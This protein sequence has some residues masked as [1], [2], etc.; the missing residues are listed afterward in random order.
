MRRIA[1]IFLG[2][3]IAA[4]A[5]D[6]AAAQSEVL[7][8]S[9]SNTIGERLAPALARKFAAAPPRGL[10]IERLEPGA[11][12]EQ[13]SLLFSGAE[14][15]RRLQVDIDSRG[16][17][18]GFPALAEHR[19]DIAMASREVTPHEENDIVREPLRSNAT[20]W[21]IGMD[22]VLV[23]VQPANPIGRLRRDQIENIFC[24]RIGGL[25]NPHHITD[26]S[27]VGGH[28]GRIQVYRRNDASGTTATFKALAMQPCSG[29]QPFPDTARDF[30]S[31]E[32]LSDAV[33]AD[34]NGIGYAGLAARRNSKAVDIA[35]TC[36]LTT[37]AVA[38]NVKTEEYPLSRELRLYSPV[39]RQTQL[40]KDFVSFATT[41][42]QAR[43]ALQETGY[44]DLELI[45]AEP[46]Y[47]DARHEADILPG[48][49]IV[50][51]TRNEYKR[52]SSSADRLSAAIRF[53]SGHADLDALASA[54][55]DKIVAAAAAGKFANRTLYLL[56]FTDDVGPWEDNLKLSAD[57][58][59]AVA[60]ILQH[61]GVSPV[62][63]SGLS[64]LVPVA[65]N[66][67]DPGRALNRRVEVWLSRQ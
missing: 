19:A 52:V 37:R 34:A 12:P 7:R 3:L 62:I 15:P 57:R 43:A 49:D 32:D 39:S 14:N 17:D 6:Q 60:T 5:S 23:L 22:G 35:G 4:A 41:T 56:G 50:R 55:I 45:P 66:D 65:C 27:Q 46:G 26:W 36:G 10:P 8:L 38:F 30:S 13:S 16:T 51:H 58:A 21:T 29:S 47:A 40:V 2:G 1:I 11:S 24:A 53:R 44:Y 18:F 67:D 31:S 28:P 9:G 25:P 20:E 59:R 61:R 48:A 54:G 63:A 42:P 64:F 33:A